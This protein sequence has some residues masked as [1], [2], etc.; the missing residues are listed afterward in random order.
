MSLARQSAYFVLK[1]ISPDTGG[2][3]FPHLSL[4]DVDPIFAAGP[5]SPVVSYRGSPTRRSPLSILTTLP[6]ALIE[7]RGH[8]LTIFQCTH[9]SYAVLLLSVPGVRGGVEKGDAG[10][11]GGCQS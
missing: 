5:S 4:P 6:R 11:A 9:P 8:K 10:R 2:I 3:L 7:G 1:A